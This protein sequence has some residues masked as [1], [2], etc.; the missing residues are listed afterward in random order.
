MVVCTRPA[1][2]ADGVRVAVVAGGYHPFPVGGGDTGTVVGGL[3]RVADLYPV[4][5]RLDGGTTLGFNPAEL[6]RVG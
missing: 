6:V 3:D 2:F 1:E 4:A 5:V